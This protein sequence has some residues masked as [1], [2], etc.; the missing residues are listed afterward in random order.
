MVQRKRASGVVAMK[1]SETVVCIAIIVMLIGALGSYALGK[2]S[3]AIRAAVQSFSA[4]VDDARALAQT[5][6]NGAT[7]A[8]AS[9]GNGG[10]TAS[11]YPYRPIPGASLDV[12]PVRTLR[13]NVTLT[14]LAIFISSSGTASAASWTPNS[15]ALAT[16]PACET[17]ISLTFGDG[18][19]NEA[20]IIPCAMAALQ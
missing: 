20:H 15:G 8:I 3:Y 4:F 5:S 10:F 19:A 1:L 6:G 7:I 16:E 12:Q 18:V 17:P 2:K 13:T 14:P 11:L 9:D